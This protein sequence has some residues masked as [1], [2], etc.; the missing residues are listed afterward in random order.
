MIVKLRELRES[1]GKTQEE[2]A[3]L[4]G[5]SSA[6]AYSLKERGE[7]KFSLDEAKIIADSF[8]LRIED[9]F[10]ASEITNTVI[11]NRFN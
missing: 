10:F 3:E 9:I 11:T 7:R 1:S 6:N 4:I 8:N 5:L 2:M